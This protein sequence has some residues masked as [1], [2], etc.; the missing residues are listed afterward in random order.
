LLTARKKSKIV[1][2][3]R[4]LRDSIF[5]FDKSAGR[6]SR[7]ASGLN[8]SPA[9]KS[10]R[11]VR[12]VLVFRGRE[13]DLHRKAYKRS[14]SLT[15]QVSGRIRV[16]APLQMPRERIE[17][18]LL[19][20]QAW[21]EAN[22][23]RYK[24]LREAFPRKDYREGESFPFLGEPLLL[25]F[26]EGSRRKPVFRRAGT[27]LVCEIPG[28]RWQGF[29]RAVGHPE[30]APALADFYAAAGKV[31][32]GERVKHFAE[33]MQLFPSSVR[34]RSQKTRWGSCSSRGRIS[35]NWRLAI[36]S[37]DVIDYVVVHELSHL[38]HYNHSALFWRLVATQVPEY[39]AY[40][41]W[42][43]VH[44][45]DGDFLAKTSELYDDR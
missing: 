39:K 37:L 11:V 33:R 15:L 13:I 32:I 1:S 31:V 5:S 30:L 4:Y 6:L 36:A 45:Y 27:E 42:L 9:A 24:A 41:D 23:V 22:L 17:T 19:A 21:I 20:H 12:E 40:R 29:D 18:F 26:V 2:M 10:R 8:Q 14:I 43:R 16:S 38:K 3:F 7:Q 44:Q 25:R 35:L 28:E 34:F